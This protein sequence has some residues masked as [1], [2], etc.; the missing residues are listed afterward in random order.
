MK[1]YNSGDKLSCW[2]YLNW[3]KLMRVKSMTKNNK[4][5]WKKGKRKKKNR[6]NV[7]ASVYNIL[8][9]NAGWT[10]GAKESTKAT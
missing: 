7:M 9:W 6:P 1:D 2:M 3:T 8:W 5:A 10:T 4:K